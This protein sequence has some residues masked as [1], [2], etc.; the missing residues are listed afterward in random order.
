ML[1]LLVLL[2]PA[3]QETSS[4]QVTPKPTDS[5]EPITASDQ[6]DSDINIQDMSNG[7]SF[8]KRIV[9]EILDRSMTKFQHSLLVEGKETGGGKKSPHGNYVNYDLVQTVIDA[10]RET[11]K[12]EKQEDSITPTGV[13]TLSPTC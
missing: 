5:Q 11:N 10:T 3:I 6:Q 7:Q 8:A 4:G 1:L 9:A 12:N 13:F 2:F